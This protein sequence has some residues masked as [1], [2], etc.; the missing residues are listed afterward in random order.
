MKDQSRLRIDDGL[1]AL[2]VFETLFVD[3]SIAAYYGVVARWDRNLCL[4]LVGVEDHD[5]IPPIIT[6][7]II[8]QAEGHHFLWRL[9][10]LQ[11]LTHQIGITQ[12]EGG[13]VLAEGDEILV[14]LKHLW[15]FRLV[16]PIQMIPLS[17]KGTP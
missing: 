14:I 13:V 11:M 7:C 9:D 16:R 6:P 1:V 8:L 5:D 2:E 12:T 4:C 15:I 10:K 3:L 17:M